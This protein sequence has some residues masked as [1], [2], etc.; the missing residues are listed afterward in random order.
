MPLVH[1]ALAALLGVIEG[2]TEYLPVS[3][4]GHLVLTEHAFELALRSGALRGP[5]PLETDGA[6]AFDIVIQLGAI[7]A[8]LVHYRALLWARLV[9][10]LRV[11]G[12]SVSLLAALAIGFLPTAVTGLL[13][14]KLIKQY[15]FAPVPIAV[16][17]IVG[18]VVMIVVER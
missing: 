4:T 12:K 13:L 2:L 11:E 9:G 10:L 18:G 16:A 5:N 7:L 6:K 15:L 3:S 8:V 14:R 1:P 17:L